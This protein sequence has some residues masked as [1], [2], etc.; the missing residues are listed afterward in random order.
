MLSPHS[1]N[2]GPRPVWKDDDPDLCDLYT[3]SGADNFGPWVGTKALMLAV[4]ENGI[5]SFLGRSRT[6]ANEAER[7]IYNYGRQSPFAF[8]VVC[9]TLR[10]DPGAVRK[11]LWQMKTGTASRKAISRSRHNVRIPGRVRIRGAAR[12]QPH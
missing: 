12:A 10:L 5:R 4:L 11:R 6:L 2:P 1:T 7:W 3:V 9:E 8:T